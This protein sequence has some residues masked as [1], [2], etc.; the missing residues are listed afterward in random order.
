MVTGQLPPREGERSFLQ[1]WK[2]VERGKGLVVRSGQKSPFP[3][4]PTSEAGAGGL[5]DRLKGK[6]SERPFAWFSFSCGERPHSKHMEWSNGG[7]PEFNF[8]ELLPAALV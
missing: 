3:F 5:V 8:L 7:G 6:Q 2:M 4:K 1:A